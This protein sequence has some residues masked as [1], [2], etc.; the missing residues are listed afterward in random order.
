ME[1][2]I[3]IGAAL[4]ISGLIGIFWCVFVVLRARRANLPDAALR[5]K[6]QKVVAWNMGAFLL[7]ALGLVMVVVG[8]FLA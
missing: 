2:L 3:W 6:L 5:A 4:T 8:V 7:S 1:S